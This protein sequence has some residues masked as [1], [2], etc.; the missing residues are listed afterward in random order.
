MSTA[1]W[2]FL[3]AAL[4]ATWQ[5]VRVTWFNA[6]MRAAVRADLAQKCPGVDGV[7]LNIAVEVSRLKAAENF[8]PLAW[9]AWLVFVLSV[10]A[11]P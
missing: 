7:T 2:I 6:K 9:A 10:K 3:A 5:P 4:L 8:W 1:S 11:A